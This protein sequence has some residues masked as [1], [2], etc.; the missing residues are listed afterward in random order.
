ML[1][2]E[3]TGHTDTIIT[4]A[5]RA[6]G[7]RLA[8]ASWDGTVRVWDLAR[9]QEYRPILAA[10]GSTPPRVAFAPGGERIAVA[11]ASGA[12]RVIDVG[13][14]AAACT[15]PEGAPIRR[16]AWIGGEEVAVVREKAPAV[17]V[18]S[19]AGCAVAATLEHPAPITAMSIGSGPQ[20]V[21]AAGG[22]VR[23]WRRG[24]VEASFP[25]HTGNIYKVGLDG[26]DVYAITELPSAIAVDALA[27]TAPR[28]H[29]RYG[30]YS[31]VDVWFDRA[32][33]RVLAPALDQFV[34]VWNAA[35]G[36]LERRLEG[37]GPLTAVR[38][39]PDGKLLIGVGG[40]SPAIWDR[41]TGARLGQLEGH[42]DL[43]KDGDFIDDRIFVSIAGNHT[44]LAWDV[45]ARRPLT[46]FRDVDAIAFSDDR[47]SV[48]L[49]GAAGVRI[50]TPRAPAPDLDAIRALVPK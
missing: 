33:G 24:R 25:G 1:L 16:L 5:L 41:A 17:E 48:A 26:D 12:L 22:V 7:G 45:E 31:G 35:T 14:G 29:Y 36:E 49:V 18:W 28:R 40:L 30:I 19:V 32:Y 3:L 50:W 46:T 11:H 20:L 39:S 27:G 34:Y 43:V 37:T 4:S 2:G 10:R 13:S 44:A 47:R 42:S 6:D 15:T 9:A 8:T 23:V 38:V 21:T